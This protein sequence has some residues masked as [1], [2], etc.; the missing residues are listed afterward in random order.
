VGGLAE[1]ELSNPG[2]SPNR[3]QLTGLAALGAKHRM[4]ELVVADEAAADGMVVEGYALIK[5]SPAR[6]PGALALGGGE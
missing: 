4:A 3:K 2:Q 1:A 5:I 6:N